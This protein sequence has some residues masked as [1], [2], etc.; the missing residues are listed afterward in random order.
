MSLATRAL[1]RLGVRGRRTGLRKLV[2][3]VLA[4]ATVCMFVRATDM[5]VL[6]HQQ[7][8]LPGEQLVLEGWGDLGKSGSGS[9]VCRYF[10]GMAVETAVFWYSPNNVLG[11]DRCAVV[12]RELHTLRR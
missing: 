2:T 1:M 12:R 8:V 9:L 4:V 3:M 7:I 6:V 11:L 10:T 5:H